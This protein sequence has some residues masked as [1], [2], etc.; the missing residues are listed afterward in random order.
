M[1]LVMKLSSVDHMYILLLQSYP[2]NTE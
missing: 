2:H 1:E